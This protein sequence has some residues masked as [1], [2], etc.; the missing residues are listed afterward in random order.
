MNNAPWV[1][2]IDRRMS[3]NSRISGTAKARVISLD[4]PKRA[5]SCKKEIRSGWCS[6]I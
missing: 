1:V 4:P 5:A 2:D 3:Q 6:I